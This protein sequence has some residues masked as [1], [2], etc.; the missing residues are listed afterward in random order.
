[1]YRTP[2]L[3][4]P[5]NAIEHLFIAQEKRQNFYGQAFS[6]LRVKPVSRISV[7]G[8]TLP[9]TKKAVRR[10]APNKFPGA[11]GIINPSPQPRQ[12]VQ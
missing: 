9:E 12:I 10:A 5:P 8:I 7:I 6:T 3:Q 2:A 4:H 1:M 11:D